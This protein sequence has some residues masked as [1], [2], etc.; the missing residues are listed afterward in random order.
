MKNQKNTVSFSDT[1]N[2]LVY[3]IANYKQCLDNSVQQILNSFVN[4]VLEY[5]HFISNKISMKNTVY[6]NFIF[7]RGF[8][9]MMHVFSITLY[10][11]KNLELTIYHTQ[12]AYYF[13]IEFIEQISDDNITFL[14]LSSRDAILFVYR[15]TIFDLSNEYKKNIHKV[16]QDERNTFDIVDSYMY[17]YKTV[18][19]FI[20]NHKDFKYD[21]R[22]AYI[23]NCCNHIEIVCE[24]L[25]KHKIKK[26][27]IDFVCLFTKLLVD[28]NL[29]IKDF[30]KLLDEFVKKTNIKKK[31]DVKIITNKIYD[32]EINTFII[33]NELHKIVDWV[34]MD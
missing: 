30:F 32:T 26:N 15:K 31:T 8:E 11:T 12:K 10:Y 4:V 22:I 17:I 13:Y 24:S 14:Q 1:A 5:M 28:K 18:I 21:N 20:T 29:D 23:N 3:N 19:K 7:E 25:N 6:Y 33:N 27:N 16:S 9:T 2:Y 34:Y